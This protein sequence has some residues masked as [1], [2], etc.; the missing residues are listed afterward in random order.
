[1]NVTWNI[2]LHSL[3]NWVVGFLSPVVA[4][5][6]RQC[7]FSFLSMFRG[8]VPFESVGGTST[9]VLY[10]GLSGEFKTVTFPCVPVL[11]RTSDLNKN[12]YTEIREET[13]HWNISFS[14]MLWNVRIQYPWEG[15][16]RVSFFVFRDM[17]DHGWTSRTGAKKV[18]SPW[19]RPGLGRSF[20]WL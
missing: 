5:Q 16:P 14:L 8:E 11:Y 7:C 18:G 10:R 12:K 4:T 1:M 17:R 13:Y 2:L 15:G 3:W 6:S 19:R 9:R 20:S